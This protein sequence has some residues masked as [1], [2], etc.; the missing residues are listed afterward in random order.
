ME[1]MRDLSESSSWYLAWMRGIPVIFSLN[2][3]G[4]ESPLWNLLGWAAL[5]TSHLSTFLVFSYQ[6]YK[7]SQKKRKEKW[8]RK[9]KT[10][11]QQTKMNVIYQ[12]TKYSILNTSYNSLSSFIFKD[13]FYIHNN[14]CRFIHYY[15]L[16][17]WKKEN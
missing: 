16:H 3:S 2:L 10:L 14:R 15:F 12:C 4:I 9:K 6:S 5:L 11:K 7:V 13:L 1:E 8:E 17:N